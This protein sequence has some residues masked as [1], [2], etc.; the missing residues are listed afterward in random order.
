MIF[1]S[2]F[3]RLK[4]G[5]KP[6]SWRERPATIPRLSSLQLMWQTSPSW[7]TE[8]RATDEDLGVTCGDLV[9]CISEFL[10]ESQSHDDFEN[11]PRELRASIFQTF[12]LNR[13]LGTPDMKLPPGFCRVD[14]LGQDTIFDGI[15]KDSRAR[16]HQFEY[17]SPRDINRCI[18]TV[19]QG[20]QSSMISEGH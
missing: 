12:S 14:W 5:S 2:G 9:D 1:P 4:I 19:R 13:K 18:W 8:I 3:V 16:L 17:E 6:M 20:K 15:E 10:R 11:E 7:I